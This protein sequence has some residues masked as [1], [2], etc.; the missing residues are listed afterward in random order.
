MGFTEGRFVSE[1]QLHTWTCVTLGK[2][3]HSLESQV[4]SYDGHNNIL[5]GSIVKMI[6]WASVWVA[7]GLAAAPGPSRGKWGRNASPAACRVYTSPRVFALEMRLKYSCM[8]IRNYDQQVRCLFEI[9]KKGIQNWKMFGSIFRPLKHG[10]SIVELSC[11]L[12]RPVSDWN[13]F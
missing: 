10:L 12:F 13:S 3:P 6:K 2:L 4:L 1:S 7:S 9:S 8:L 5:P 11:H